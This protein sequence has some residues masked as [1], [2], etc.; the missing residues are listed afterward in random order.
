MEEKSLMLIG[1]KNICWKNA[2]R[3]EWQSKRPRCSSKNAISK[4]K[5]DR[6]ISPTKKETVFG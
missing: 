1:I 2:I 3:S 5:V 6:L 4:N